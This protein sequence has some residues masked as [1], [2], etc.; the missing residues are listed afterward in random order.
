[1][2]DGDRIVDRPARI[3]TGD[4]TAQGYPYFSGTG[5]YRGSV[6]VPSEWLGSGRVFLEADCGE[7]VL[8]VRFNGGDSRVAPWHP[9]RIEVTDDLREG[10]ND[11]EIRVTNT[12][13]NILE[14]IKHPSG[15]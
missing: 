14:G 9:Y 15:L 5:V 7:D 3:R 4:W 6:D 2:V 12:L 11:V 8:D 1:G 10:A 13:M